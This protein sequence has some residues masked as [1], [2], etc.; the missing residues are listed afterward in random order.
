MNPSNQVEEAMA[1]LDDETRAL[2]EL[3]SQRRMSDA[4]LADLLR[5]DQEEVAERRRRAQ[6]RLNLEMGVVGDG[7]PEPAREHGGGRGRWI[8]AGVGGLVVA[9]IVAIVLASGND[10]SDK[11]K[12]AAAAPKSGSSQPAGS[13]KPAAPAN[14]PVRTMQVL[15]QTHGR[16]TAQLAGGRLRLRLHDFLTPNAGG[17][18]VWL[19]NSPS[20]ARLLYAT[21]DT[22][23]QTDLA[24][25][26]GYRRYRYVDVARAVPQ[27]RSPHSG[28][29]LLRVPLAELR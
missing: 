7:L 10:S 19:Y 18:A 17:Y 13:S 28:L 25:P 29:S 14:G 15:N 12:P 20:D 16:G 26:A 9:A 11:G 27:L 21:A 5:L 4:D 23:I 1:R 22:T 3:S 6:Q 2:L 8:A 24:L